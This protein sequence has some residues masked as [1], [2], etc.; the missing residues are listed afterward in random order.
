MLSFIYSSGKKPKLKPKIKPK[1]KPS[2][3]L[4]KVGLIINGYNRSASTHDS[5]AQDL[6]LKTV[7]SRT[8]IRK[9]TTSRCTVYLFTLSLSRSCF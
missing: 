6:N 2:R 9:T 1:I 4:K 5:T 8:A 7:F 3:K